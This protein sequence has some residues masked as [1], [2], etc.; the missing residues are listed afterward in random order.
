MSQWL[1]VEEAAKSLNMSTR[2]IQ[3]YIKSGKVKT[4]KIGNSR[5]ILKDSVDKIKSD[6][7]YDEYT[8]NNSSSE[9]NEN[10]SKK[11]L[12]L[13]P[14]KGYVVIDNETLE[15]LRFQIKSLTESVSQMQSTQK[16][17]I[18]KGLNLNQEPKELP[19]SVTRTVSGNQPISNE[20]KK[21]IAITENPLSKITDD[22]FSERKRINKNK[23]SSLTI[24]FL[25]TFILI[26]LIV[27]ANILY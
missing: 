20:T 24:I 3:R 8:E 2:T 23:N 15:S 9:A 27:I 26:V 19:I 22:F 13:Q 16:L 18:E 5:S 21:E 25:A 14:P 12:D 4:K 11:G 6:Q 1:T 7:N 10:S 17:L